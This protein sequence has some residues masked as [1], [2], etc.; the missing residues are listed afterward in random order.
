MPVPSTM[1]ALGTKAPD[2]TLPE[3][4]ADRTVSLKDYAGK[5]VL[6]GF[7]CNHCP[8]VIH[9][10]GKLGELTSRWSDQGLTVILINANDVEK[11][12]D[13]APEKMPAFAR[14]N[15]ITV[16]YLY[17]ETQET[18]KA[19]HAACT[20]D[21][22]LFNRDHTLV[23]RGQFDDSRPGNDVAVTGADLNAAVEALLAG[24]EI[25]SEQKASAGCNIKWKPGNEPGF[26]TLG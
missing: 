25:P 21:F 20:P 12:P 6:V 16:P 5:P 10:G 26:Y 14:E 1:R 24:S 22:F 7:I 9:I 4:G 3:P 18:A 19:Y 2:F 13:D 8:Y 23:Y 15:G 17:D 11:H